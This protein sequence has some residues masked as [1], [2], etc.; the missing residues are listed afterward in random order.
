MDIIKVFKCD[1]ET[2][3]KG[4]NGKSQKAHDDKKGD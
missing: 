2:C 4:D 1:S 3:Q